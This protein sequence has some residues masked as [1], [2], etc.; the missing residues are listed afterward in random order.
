VISARVF[1]IARAGDGD[2]RLLGL[3]RGQRTHAGAHRA[4]GQQETQAHQQKPAFGA[5]AAVALRLVAQAQV[6]AFDRVGVLAR[7]G[8]PR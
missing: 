2:A 7:S 1:R 3:G 4:E 5:H 8:A 6:L